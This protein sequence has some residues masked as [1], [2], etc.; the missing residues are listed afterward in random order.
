MLLLAYGQR[1]NVNSEII[2]GNN[3]YKQKI[4]DQSAASYKK[5]LEVA[6]DNPVANY[7]LG[8][9]RFRTSQFDE[10]V[11]SFDAIIANSSIKPIR[12]KSFYN[13]G[14]AYSKQQ[15]LDESIEAWKNAL[16]LDPADKEAR[17]NLQKALL[18]KKKEQQKQDQKKDKKD[19]KKEDQKKDKN[20][21]DQK[22][23]QQQSKLNKKQVEQLLKALAQKEKEVQQKMQQQNA[24]PSKQ[25]KD[26]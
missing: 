13:K 11:N 10:A 7:N 6:P 20:K 12:E 24:S 14:V 26:W 16:K 8:N 22:P 23:E 19:K 18:E 3:L 5:A 21:Q 9:A 15:K 2:N 17:E 1:P 25:D 4:F